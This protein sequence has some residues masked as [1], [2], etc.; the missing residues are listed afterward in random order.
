MSSVLNTAVTTGAGYS[1]QTLSARDVFSAEIWFAAMPIMKWDQFTTR[2]TEL[3][4]QAGRVIQMPK[5]NAIRRGGKLTEGVR[6]QTQAMSMSQSSITIDERGNALGF[7]ELLLQTSF[8]DQLAAASLLLGRDMA[9]VLDSEIRNTAATGINTVF[10]NSKV[11]RTGLVSTDYFDTDLIRDAVEVLEVGNA[12]KWGADH[13]ICFLHPHQAG[14]LRRDADWISAAEYSGV[15]KIYT[16]EIG[17]FE[18]VR[19]VSTTVMP[20]GF[21]ST[22]DPNTG[23]FADIGYTAALANGSAGNQTTI[24][25]AIFFGQ[26]AVGHATGLPV[27]MRDNGVEDYGREHG[28]AWYAIWG[29]GVLETANIVIGETA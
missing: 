3:G 23:D 11:A 25:Q 15:E 2:K 27:E 13:Y 18:D 26:Y 7:S 8:Y 28:L 19:F 14:R 6:L 20:N 29:H 1:Q 5:F 10:P 21:N 4:T 12:P 16:G 24:Y 9:I 22:V 17:R